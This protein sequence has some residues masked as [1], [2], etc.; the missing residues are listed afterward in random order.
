MSERRA[1]LQMACDVFRQ[2]HDN[3]MEVSVGYYRQDWRG[4]ASL[5]LLFF[6]HHVSL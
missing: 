4:L 5:I 3:I 1:R 2:K 6:V